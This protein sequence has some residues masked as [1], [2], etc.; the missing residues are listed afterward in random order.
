MQHKTAVK[1]ILRITHTGIIW[2]ANTFLNA[3][4]KQIF[5][6]HHSVTIKSK[7]EYVK[8]KINPLFPCHSL[9]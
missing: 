2:G 7:I 5:I 4:L 8:D 9:I 6:L 1:L 3:P